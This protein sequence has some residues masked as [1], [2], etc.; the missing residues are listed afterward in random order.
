MSKQDKGVKFK[1]LED[2]VIELR[3]FDRPNANSYFSWKMPINEVN[4]LARW[5]KNEGMHVKKKQLP[6]NEHKFG[7]ILISMFTH[8]RVDIRGFDRYGGVKLLGYSLP[9]KVVEHLGIWLQDRQLSQK[10]DS[11]KE[12]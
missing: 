12:A 2:N 3:Y 8:A 10:S 6:M 4:D 9:L 1:K 5:W 7:S 11:R